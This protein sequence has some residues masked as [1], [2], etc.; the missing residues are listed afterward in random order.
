MNFDNF[1]FSTDDLKSAE[2]AIANPYLA[3]PAKG[4][5]LI[6]R[7]IAHPPPSVTQNQ[8]KHLSQ[9]HQLIHHDYINL[10]ARD[11]YPAEA[12][13][14]RELLA[15]EESLE[16]LV[17]FPDLANK[18]I[19]G[20]G[21]G[22]SAGKSRFLN[23][24]LGTTLLP[25]ALEPTTAIP[26]FITHGQA[27]AIVAVNTFNHP[28]E[29]DI[30]AL[31]AISHAFYKHYKD[32]L[33]EEVG[34]AHILK[35]LMVRQPNFIW[36]NLAFLDTPGYSKAEDAAVAVFTDEGVALKQL[37]EADYIV[38]LVDSSNGS[39]RQDDLH[40]LK[41]LAPRQPIFVVITKADCKGSI[42][43]QSIIDSTINSLKENNIPT[44]GVM[45]WAAP[46]D[47]ETGTCVAGDDFHEWLQTLNHQ[48]KRT[49]KRVTCAR[50]MD[51]CLHFNAAALKRNKAELAALNELLPML[52]AL[53]DN[54]RATINAMREYLRQS[55][56]RLEELVNGFSELR[57]NMLDV[58][59]QIVGTVAQDEEVK[60]GQAMAITIDRK[61]LEVAVETG[62]FYTA[63]VLS[64]KQDT[65]RVL[66]RIGKDI[67]A[68]GASFSAVRDGLGVDP[69]R[70][71]IGTLFRCEIHSQDDRQVHLI[72]SHQ[73]A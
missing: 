24:L 5:G 10:A 44:A 60:K 49:I 2:S 54:R 53:P 63:S 12:Q 7:L 35:L 69:M 62:S 48:P 16:D 47:K 55:Q 20:V 66:F 70:I 68:A 73:H 40:F 39:I 3:D 15:L 41:K 18:K 72:F 71:A 59:T 50:I 14:F 67:A 34:F 33:G 22:F 58:I 52:N 4:L 45:G 37:T 64:V 36:H 46:L 8:Q 17:I 32:V 19:V 26:T 38:W 13:A 21:G 11:D 43:I 42:G 61:S 27:E 29:I 31:S 25:E 56:R 28:V 57:A 65:K 23:T 51:G 9:L 30:P 6:T 1:D